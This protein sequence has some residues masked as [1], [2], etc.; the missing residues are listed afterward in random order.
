M[1]RS[2][3]RGGAEVLRR[4]TR[5]DCAGAKKQ[6]STKEVQRCRAEQSS[7]RCRAGSDEVQKSGAEVLVVQR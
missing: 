6:G 4:F 2:W 5:D 1:Q 7:T 3:C